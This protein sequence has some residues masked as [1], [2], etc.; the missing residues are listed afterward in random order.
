MSA[1]PWTELGK[2]MKRFLLL[3]VAVLVLVVGGIYFTAETVILPK[4]EKVWRA[5][6]EDLP[7][8][9]QADFGEVDFEFVGLRLSVG[10]ATISDGG[11]NTIKVSEIVAENS[12]RTALGNL[13]RFIMGR[14]EENYDVVR[15]IGV[16]PVELQQGLDL[17]IQEIRLLNVAIGIDNKLPTTMKT[18]TGMINLEAA[19]AAGKV[20]GFEVHGVLASGQGGSA[21]LDWMKVHGITRTNLGLVEVSGLDV[22]QGAQTLAKLEMFKTT[23]FNIAAIMEPRLVA[24]LA[25]AAQPGDF[26][27]FNIFHT[28]DQLLLIG[29]DLQVPGIGGLSIARMKYD[30]EESELVANTGIVPTR[31]FGVVRDFDLAFPGL[32]ALSPEAGLFMQTT[33]INA[34]QMN[35]ESESNWD[36]T[37]NIQKSGGWLDLTDLIKFTLGLELGNMNPEDLVKAIT[38]SM[39]LTGTEGRVADMTANGLMAIY[40]DITL[41]DLDYLIENNSLV[42]RLFRFAEVAAGMPESEIKALLDTQLAATLEDP[43]LPASLADDIAALRQFV[44]EPKSLRIVMQPP[45]PVSLNGFMAE[46]D[47]DKGVGMLGLTITAN[48]AL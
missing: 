44:A 37:N 7:Y 3:V 28:A 39:G 17:K 2:I 8:G 15:F 9:L 20:D 45:S 43:T 36:L 23:N 32:A 16:E 38:W 40:G 46:Q 29:L 33:G 4:Q 22:A 31:I 6:L 30:E 47:R 12:L 34:I 42:E 10:G 27:A 19:F 1:A 5:L 11:G 25:D 21:R 24:K 26:S 48:E 35:S 14:E 13:F 41:N 18:L